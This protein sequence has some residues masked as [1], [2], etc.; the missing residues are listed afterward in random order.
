MGLYR[1]K[2]WRKSNAGVSAGRVCCYFPGSGRW[3]QWLGFSVEI[4]KGLDIFFGLTSSRQEVSPL[5]SRVFCRV[6]QS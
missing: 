1:L 6:F 4:D 3:I 5:L 2:D